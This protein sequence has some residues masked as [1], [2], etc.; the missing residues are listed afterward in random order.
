MVDIAIRALSPAVND[1]TT[2]VEVLD[3]LETFLLAL[4][5]RDLDRGRIADREGNV[6]LVF[7]NSGW[8]A[9]LD[10]A[11]SEIRIF[12]SG[13]PQVTRR[14]S[15]LLDDLDNHAPQSRVASVAFQRE[16]LRLTVEAEVAS[17]AERDYGLTSDR[18]GLGTV[19]PD[20]SR[21]ETTIS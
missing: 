10:L 14:M 16:R 13:S 7:P 12:G 6:R 21:S 11:L 5:W 18:I 4:A 20:G 2:A 17:P 1:P 3:G 8:E 15:A 19:P 9:L